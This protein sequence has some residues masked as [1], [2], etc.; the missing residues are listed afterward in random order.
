[1]PVQQDSVHA[2]ERNTFFSYSFYLFIDVFTYFFLQFTMGRLMFSNPC[3][4]LV[5]DPI[6]TLVYFG[7]QCTYY[8]F[9][10]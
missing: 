8:F 9:P 7:T 6:G 1:M 4:L 2:S 3:L 5:L 10:S